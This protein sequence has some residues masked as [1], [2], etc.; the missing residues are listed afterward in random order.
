MTRGPE[1]GLHGRS[2]GSGIEKRVAL[3]SR[4]HAFDRIRDSSRTLDAL[5][6]LRDRALAV[7]ADHAA[8][9]VP[10]DGLRAGRSDPRAGARAG[11][12]PAPS[13][14]R[15]IATATSSGAIAKLDVEEDAL[16]NY[17]FVASRPAA[18]AA[19]A[20]AC[21]ESRVERSHPGL[22]DRVL[23]FVRERGH[24]RIRATSTRIT[25]AQ[26]VTNYWGGSSSAATHALDW[27]HYRGELRVVRRDARHS[28]VCAG[29]ASRA[30]PAR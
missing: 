2:F 3:C 26:S 25:A 27:L 14:R 17:G 23:A 8:G 10:E 18:A 30:R 19:S 20:R 22:L 1:S 6:A 16:V 4:G 5:R 12:D 15:T 28:R 21:A 9:G 11:P 29:G 24:R 7:H 13:R